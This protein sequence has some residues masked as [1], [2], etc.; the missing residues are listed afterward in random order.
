MVEENEKIRPEET[1]FHC[2]S[3]RPNHVVFKAPAG[4]EQQT[5]A[6]RIHRTAARDGISG[7]EM[8]ERGNERSRN[9]RLLFI[10]CMSL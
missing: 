2:N 9:S 4:R 6:E 8:E 3:R 7:S 1:P 5:K 10:S